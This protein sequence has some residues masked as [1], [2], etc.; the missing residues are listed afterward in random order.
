MLTFDGKGFYPYMVFVRDGLPLVGFDEE[1]IQK[2]RRRWIQA[3]KAVA[4]AHTS[5][6]LESVKAE[7]GNAHAAKKVVEDGLT[8]IDEADIRS[9]PHITPTED[10]LFV[11]NGI[12]TRD[13]YG[14]IAHLADDIMGLAYIDHDNLTGITNIRG[15]ANKAAVQAVPS[16]GSD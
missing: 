1:P 12:T 13:G 16:I 5:K 4:S 8:D 6:S 11:L 15:V 10:W 9:V 14:S 3:F 7:I 2:V